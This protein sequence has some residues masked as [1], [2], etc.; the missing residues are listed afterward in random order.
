MVTLCF[1]TVLYM[2]TADMGH[3]LALHSANHL[4]RERF[5]LEKKPKDYGPSL[6]L[7]QEDLRKQIALTSPEHVLLP[8]FNSTNIFIMI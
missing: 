2:R 1:A 5:V 8:A 6:L 4:N 7:K 3:R